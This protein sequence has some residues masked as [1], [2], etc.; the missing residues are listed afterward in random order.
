MKHRPENITATGEIPY[1]PG[2]AEP[3]AGESE[4]ANSP[5]P[6]PYATVL[7]IAA[8]LLLLVL[9]TSAAAWWLADYLEEAPVWHG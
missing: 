3:P 1:W 7:T 6:V 9:A 5:R 8:V 2:R 4:T